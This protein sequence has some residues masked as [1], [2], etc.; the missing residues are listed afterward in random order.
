MI[1]GLSE[2]DEVLLRSVSSD[3]TITIADGPFMVLGGSDFILNNTYDV[4]RLF[5][6]GGNVC[7]DNGRYSNGS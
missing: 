1:E 5:C 4:I 2:G 6:V 7:V 3:Q